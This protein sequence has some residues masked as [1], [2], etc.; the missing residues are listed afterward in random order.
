M[1][2]PSN[3]ILMKVGA[4]TWLSIIIL[5]WG[6][7]A[8]SFCMIKSVTGFYVLR[9]LLG[10]LH[11]SDVSLQHLL[12]GQPGH[13]LMLQHGAGTAFLAHAQVC[14]CRLMQSSSNLHHNS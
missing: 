9:F 5:A 12:L 13:H 1:Q 14:W 7:C 10:G 3:L 6:L 11:H 8:T 4:P 2:V